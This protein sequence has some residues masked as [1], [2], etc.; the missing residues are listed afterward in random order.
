MR[1]ITKKNAIRGMRFKFIHIA[2]LQD[3]ALATKR[4]EMRDGWLASKAKLK[5]GQSQD[6][7]HE[8]SIG[9]ITCSVDSISPKASRSLMLI[10][11]HPCHLN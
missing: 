9:D 2:M 10:E 4:P 7:A 6:R 11:H 5:G 1:C 3:K 8:N